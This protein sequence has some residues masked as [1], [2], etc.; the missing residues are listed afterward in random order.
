MGA[1]GGT[2]KRTDASEGSGRGLRCSLRYL[3]RG[4]SNDWRTGRV[5]G[6]LPLETLRQAADLYL[7]DAWFDDTFIFCVDERQV[8]IG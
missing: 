8:F 2:V 4:T 6:L 5:L 3:S 1:D 7:E